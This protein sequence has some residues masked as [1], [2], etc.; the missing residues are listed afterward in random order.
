MALAG[1]TRPADARLSQAATHFAERAT[2][3]PQLTPGEQ[4]ALEEFVGVLSQR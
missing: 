4:G 2:L 1:H 3:V